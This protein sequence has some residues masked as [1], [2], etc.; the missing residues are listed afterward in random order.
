MPVSWANSYLKPPVV[1][2]TAEPTADF[3]M[4]ALAA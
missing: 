1:E 2:E 4:A 3:E